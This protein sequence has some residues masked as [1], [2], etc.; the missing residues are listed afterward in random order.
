MSNEQTPEHGSRAAQFA[1]LNDAFRR[2]TR[3]VMITIRDAGLARYAGDW[4]VPFGRSIP[5]RRR[6]TPGVSMI[7]ARMLGTNSRR[8]GK[9]APTINNYHIGATR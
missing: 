8:T 2:S 6:T 5:S 7:M 9:L 1:H 4:F 3:E